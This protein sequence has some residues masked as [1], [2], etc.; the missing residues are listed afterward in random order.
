MLSRLLKGSLKKTRT[1]VLS[2]SKE[3]H[4]ATFTMANPTRTI[5]ADSSSC[6]VFDFIS[7]EKRSV[8]RGNFFGDATPDFDC[9][10]NFPYI[11]DCRKRT[12]LLKV[13]DSAQQFG[14]RSSILHKLNTSETHSFFKSFK[15]L[16]D[17]NENQ[18]F[19]AKVSLIEVN[20][21]D[22]TKPFS[23]T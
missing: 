13:A 9:K 18:P 7:A 2:I 19:H 14:F 6:P 21:S 4:Q 15:P 3:H 8:K 5:G 10:T 22:E 1:R 23:Q 16:I 17:S 12:A 11:P 20:K